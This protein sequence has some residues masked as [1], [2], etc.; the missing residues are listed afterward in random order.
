MAKLK[1]LK[2]KDGKVFYPLTHPNAVIDEQGISV[3]EKLTELEGQINSTI[4]KTY[5]KINVVPNYTEGLVRP[6]GS[7]GSFMGYVFFAPIELKPYH[8]IVLNEG[9]EFYCGDRIAS[10]YQC[11]NQGLFIKPLIIG[12]M[13]NRVIEYTNNT[14]EI[15]YLGICG[16]AAQLK[17]TL[18]NLVHSASKNELDAVENNLATEISKTQSKVSLLKEETSMVLTIVDIFPDIADTFVKERYPNYAGGYVA[19]AAEGNP[20]GYYLITGQLLQEIY[21]IKAYLRC[22]GDL[23]AAISFY[24][25]VEDFKASNYLGGIQHKKTEGEWFEVTIPE[26]AK[27]CL[28]VD[29]N[30][31]AE[32]D[33]IIYALKKEK[34]FDSL[35]KLEN[36]IKG[37]DTY[38]EEFIGEVVIAGDNT[39]GQL[40]INCRYGEII[41]IIPSESVDYLQL[42]TNRYGADVLSGI[43]GNSAFYFRVKKDVNILHFYSTINNSLPRN[44]QVYRCADKPLYDYP[45]LVGSFYKYS[46]PEITEKD[47]ILGKSFSATQG[48]STLKH[49]ATTGVLDIRNPSLKIS[50]SDSDNYRFF[51]LS[52]L[53]QHYKDSGWLTSLEEDM[54]CDRLAITIEKKNREDFTADDLKVISVEFTK[55][56]TET[57]ATPSDI[58]K[59]KNELEELQKN[60]DNKTQ[61]NALG[62]VNNVLNVTKPY[63]YHFA[64]NDFIR[65]GE[66]KR[67]IPSQT[68]YD[69]ELAARLGFTSIEANIQPTS[70]GGFICM[71]GAGG[72]F[73]TTVL[74]LDGED[75]TNTP[76]N[77]K[78][79]EWIKENVRYK[80]DYEKYKVAP[81]TLEEFCACCKING[82]GIF[83]GTNYTDAINICLKI[84]GTDNVMLYG[85]SADKRSIFKGM[86]F[87]WVNSGA[88]TIDEILTK[89]RSFGVPYMYGLGPKLLSTLVAN[90]QLSELCSKMHAEGFTLASTAVYDS[91]E[92]TLNAFELGVDFSAS[93]H[94][95]NNFEPNYFIHSLDDETT[96]SGTATINNGIVNMTEGQTIICGNED[97]IIGKAILNIRYTGELEFN[98]GSGGRRT[99]ISEGSK[100]IVLSDYFYK[101]NSR[102]TITAQNASVIHNLVYKASKC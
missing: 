12:D 20:I 83:A 36:E 15:L 24:S 58:K 52:E 5:S 32:S 95:V 55:V 39:T 68:T 63:Y 85:A 23:P 16:Q 94:Q 62:A 99:I 37:P 86:M 43:N 97:K 57:Y 60:I 53:G 88:T 79:L 61:L 14:K 74:S 65:D 50:L 10:L 70:D 17:Y 91:D 92:N 67:A 56:V 49:R 46:R 100:D 44:F 41:K 34:I 33:P 78:T 102:L 26:N 9:K 38:K 42:G 21:S 93:G 64:P 31:E 22:N 19:V 73:G 77:S 81:P 76:I 7:L 25:V 18:Y 47:W 3:G 13:T 101:R 27:A 84:L 69:I 59:V 2:D 28:I 4:D 66:N 35:S 82:I 6:D 8:K 29:R 87:S 98:F 48:V 75:I 90:N 54:E 80:S 51:I 30:V 11:D 89:A 71:H 96:I 1:S 40:E 72:N 45:Y